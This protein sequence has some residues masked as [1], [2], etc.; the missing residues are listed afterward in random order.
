MH[1][2]RTNGASLFDH[3]DPEQQHNEQAPISERRRAANRR[4]AEKSIGPRTKKGRARARFNALKHGMAAKSLAILGPDSVKA[5]RRLLKRLRREAS[6][7]GF[8][9]ERLVQEKALW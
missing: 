6:P 2:P 1:A 7:R 8:D 3:H 5:F 4:N 9:E